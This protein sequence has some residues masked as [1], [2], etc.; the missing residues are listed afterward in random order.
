MAIHQLFPQPVC[1]SKL[2]R[3]LTKKELTTIDTY[4][5]KTYKNE[6][7]LTSKDNYVL[8]NKP[9]KNLKKDLNKAVIDYFNEVVCANNSITPY[10]TQSWI[11]YTET[12]QFHHKHSHSNSYVSGV[13][14]IDA[15]KEVD[16]I[17]FYKGGFPPV[18]LNA[19]KFNVF[20][21]TTWWY[22]VQTGDIILFPSTLI[23]GVDKK[24]G[25]NTRIS[26]SFN[27]FIKGKIG[28]NARL[29][30]LVLE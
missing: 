12:N 19:I 5:A 4:Q 1:F 30:E 28:E 6:G 16:K 25:T 27:V 3:K 20:N 22:P 21:A 15:D 2:E 13:F 10:I 24:K 23:H 17:K 11:N 8:E 9:L 29:T 26:L 14:Y 7:N 18:E